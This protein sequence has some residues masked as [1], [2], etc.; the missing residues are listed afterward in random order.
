M[1]QERDG[2]RTLLL[3]V[4]ALYL[5]SIFALVDFGI[6]L[7]LF[8]RRDA[9]TTMSTSLVL[10]F[11]S[12]RATVIS[13]NPL[14]LLEAVLSV[15]YIWLHLHFAHRFRRGCQGGQKRTH[16][17]SISR[18]LPRL[19]IVF[20]I[21]ASANGLVVAAR[22]PKCMSA[23]ASHDLWR[24]GLSCTLHRSATCMAVGAL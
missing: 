6:V 24:A 14:T 5:L 19:L 16:I 3:I 22:Q 1:A 20:W 23:T 11:T 10:I 2:S 9:D 12:V 4:W 18:F 21:V 7:T 17:E 15:I 13:K 8:A